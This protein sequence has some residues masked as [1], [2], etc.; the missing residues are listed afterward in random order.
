M[1][2]KKNIDRLFQEKLK[3]FEASPSDAVW[4]NIHEKLHENKRKKRRVLPIWWQL[5]GVAAALLLILVL[6]GVFNSDSTNSSSRPS[7]SVVNESNNENRPA[8]NTKTKEIKQKD[9]FKQQEETPELLVDNNQQSLKKV[10]EHNTNDKLVNS[11]DK[12]NESNRTSK[13]NVGSTLAFNKTVEENT[14]LTSEKG[15]NSSSKD[16]NTKKLIND[17]TNELNSA[18]TD[19]SLN[20]NKKEVSNTELVKETLIEENALENAIAEANEEEQVEQ[21]ET[22]EKRWSIAPNVAPVYFNSLN[23]G[24]SIHS[25]FN[26]N[27]KSGDINMS[28]GITGAYAVNDKLKVRAGINRV[29]LGYSTNDV[30]FYN[31]PQA[32]A[33]FDLNTSTNSNSEMQNI[34]LRS[35]T[36]N[37]SFLSASSLSLNNTPEII[38]ENALVSIDQQFG[39][40]EIP[41]ELEY[42]VMDKRLSLNLIGGFSTMFLNNNDIYVVANNG[43]RTLIGEANNINE[44]SYSAN[45]GLGLNYGLS[46]KLNINLEPMFKYQINTFNNTFGDFQPFFIGV[47]TGLSFKF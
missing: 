21:D 40:I 27:I 3:D 9:S 33:G 37:S 8:S 14:N 35:E 16:L 42:K 1:S 6:S 45:F 29:D 28:Y 10:Q 30:I 38:K 22:L 47:Y 11:L 39:F 34:N 26:E 46:D 25:Q 31:N 36:A 12:A 18:I 32:I 15:T 20:K 4:E 44:L 17:A 2:E 23:G 24:S 43:E 5:G 19:T 41:V 7:N 13:E